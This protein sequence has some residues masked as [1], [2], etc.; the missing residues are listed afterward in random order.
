VVASQLHD[1]WNFLIFESNGN[2]ENTKE[3][4]LRKLNDALRAVKAGD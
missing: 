2:L 4:A 1:L 3:I